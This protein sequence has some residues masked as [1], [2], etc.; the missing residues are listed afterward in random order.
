M[1]SRYFN[2]VDFDAV[3]YHPNQRN[4]S[5]LQIL[6][7]VHLN[8][9]APAN[10]SANEDSLLRHGKRYKFRRWPAGEW[11]IFQAQF[12]RN[13]EDYFNWPTMG[14]WLL[15][16]PMESLPDWQTELAEFKHPHPISDRFRPIVQC[17]LSVTLVPSKAQSHVSFDVLRLVDN[18]SDFRSFVRMKHNQQETGMLTHQDISMQ[19]PSP[20]RK[21]QSVVSHEVGHALGLHHSN[22]KDPRCAR[23][24]NLDICY[25][26]RGSPERRNLMGAGNEIT[27]ADALP[28][29][30]AVLRLT[31]SLNWYPTDQLPREMHFL[32]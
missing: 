18:A 10:P 31:P 14:L 9:R 32:M 16:T 3:L 12:K 25:G 21:Q 15:P 30:R 2:D 6:L 17:G 28:W 7:R 1:I 11:S 26:R 23:N 19:A 24:G 4:I 20:N 5:E 29:V 22:Y 8:P 27:I 13:V